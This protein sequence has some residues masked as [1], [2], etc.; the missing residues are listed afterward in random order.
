MR[1]QS[2]NL[3][4][5]L[6][7]ITL[8]LV[9]SAM[10]LYAVAVQIPVDIDPSTLS[11]LAIDILLH[12]IVSQSQ[13]ASDD[14]RIARRSIPSCPPTTLTV[15]PYVARLVYMHDQPNACNVDAHIERPTYNDYLDLTYPEL[16]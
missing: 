5:F 10:L 6:I 11:A 3:P 8:R 15:I 1:S 14:N 16:L 7:L 2:L 12:S 9:C 4:L 13:T